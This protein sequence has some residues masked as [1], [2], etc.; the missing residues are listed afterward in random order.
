M[1]TPTVSDVVA[2]AP[3]L[4]AYAAT[5]EGAAF[6]TARIALAALRVDEDTWGELYSHALALMAAHLTLM[7]RPS[8]GGLLSAGGI[9]QS[10]TVGSA[11]ESYATNSNLAL[12]L[13]S[14]TRPGMLYDSE[15]AARSPGLLMV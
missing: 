5:T 10:Q 7:A 9:L 2:E 15:L 11:S 12:G 13:N 4:T 6:I 3:E 14:F 8:L 1:A